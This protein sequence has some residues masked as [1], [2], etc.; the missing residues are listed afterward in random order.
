MIVTRLVFNINKLIN[1]SKLRQ[2]Y[3]DIILIST[4]TITPDPNSDLG[5]F[6][7]LVK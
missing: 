6:C 3:Q 2:T 1:F 5:N 7:L 4:L